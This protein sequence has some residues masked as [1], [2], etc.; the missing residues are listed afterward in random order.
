MSKKWVVFFHNMR[1]LLRY[2]LNGESEGE[3]E[4]T[5]ALLAYERGI[6]EE[7]IGWKIVEGGKR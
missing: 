3:R 5:I 2:S 4:E 7:E 1:E 6:P